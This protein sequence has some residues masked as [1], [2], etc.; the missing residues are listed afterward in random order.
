[1]VGQGAFVSI[2]YV[3]ALSDSDEIDGSDLGEPLEYL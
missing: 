3:L 2:D 1:M